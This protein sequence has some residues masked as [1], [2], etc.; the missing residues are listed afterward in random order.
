[1]NTLSEQTVLLY[2]TLKVT[3]IVKRFIP[4]VP[5]TIMT[6]NGQECYGQV[7]NKY[8]IQWK[9]DMEIDA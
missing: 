7:F 2:Q 3:V 4:M 5:L 8:N 1:M 6:F 9:M